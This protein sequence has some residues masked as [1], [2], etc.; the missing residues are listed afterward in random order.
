MRFFSPTAVFL[1]TQCVRESPGALKMQFLIQ[2]VWGGTHLSTCT[3][4]KVPGGEDAA[5]PRGPLA[6]GK[7]KRERMSETVLS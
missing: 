5:D 1:K 6:L 2:W 3:S 7:E 4:S